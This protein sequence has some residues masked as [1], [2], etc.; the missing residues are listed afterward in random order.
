MKKKIVISSDKFKSSLSSVEVADI[1]GSAILSVLPDTEIVKIPVADGGEGSMEILTSY[2]NGR[3]RTVEVMNPLMSPIQSQYGIVN[4]GQTAIIELATASG[5][6]LLSSQEYNPWVT[7]TYGTGQLIL[8]ALQNDCKE[9]IIGIGGSATND[10]GTGLLQALGY[11]FLDVERQELNKGG[12]ILEQISSID[13][14]LRE[15]LLDNVSF[16]IACD[17]S[18]PF[19]GKEGAAYVFAPQKG[20]SKTMVERLDNGLRHFA[21]V[22]YEQWEI[23]VQQIQGSGA[24]GGVGGTMRAFLDADLE[25][26]IDLILDLLEFDKKIAGADLIITGEGKIDNQ[27]AGGKAINGITKRAA[28][29]HIPV[30]AFAGKVE[31]NIRPEG[32]GLRKAYSINQEHLP[33]EKA[34]NPAVAK[35]NLYDKVREVFIQESDFNNR[36]GK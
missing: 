14:S 1:I 10:A 34:I 22:I 21:S 23:D 11:R 35:Q 26:G 9:F 15:P 18:N 25:S 36:K 19:Y 32:I 27:T 7:T 4:G 8:D 24:A 3:S 29:Q 17:V 13:Y 28:K 2:L 33:L 16:R 5:L 6:A 20:A 31:N 30:I 12:Q